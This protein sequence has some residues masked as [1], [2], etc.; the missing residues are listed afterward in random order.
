MNVS[1]GRTQLNSGGSIVR[2]RDNGTRGSTL[3]TVRCWAAVCHLPLSGSDESESGN[4]DPSR[5]AGV[6]SWNT[7][8][9]LPTSVKI[10]PGQMGF[11]HPAIGPD[12]SGSAPLSHQSAFR[13]CAGIWIC[14]GYACESARA[15]H[16][17]TALLFRTTVALGCRPAVGT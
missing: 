8:A 3:T 10:L 9:R 15:G 12:P 11:R 17:A 16:V 2:G 4:I 5:E 13:Y 7:Y 14:I 1:L 6:Q